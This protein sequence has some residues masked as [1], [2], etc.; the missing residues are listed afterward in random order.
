MT[1][2][3]PGPFDNEEAADFIEDL[4]EAPD[5]RTVIALLE[6]VSSVTGY[7]EEPEGEMA[8]AAAGIVASCVGAGSVLPDTHADL[9]AALGAPPEGSANLARKALAR[10]VGPASELDETWQEGE[11]HD[12]W[13]TQIAGLQSLLNGQS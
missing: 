12:A 11:D 1:A 3:A 5:W 2:W 6:H 8:V 9:K 10:I 13:L 7:L 4:T